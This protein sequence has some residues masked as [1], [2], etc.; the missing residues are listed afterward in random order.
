MPI[1]PTNTNRPGN[2][3][4]AIAKT[5]LIIA[6]IGAL[7]WGLVGLFQFNL[8][9][10]IFGG[11][12]PEQPSAAS[13]VVYVIVGLAGVVAAFLLPKL[14]FDARQTTGYADRPL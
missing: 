4:G 3:G 1:M 12:A 11:A 6:I 10:A 8:V 13:R 5:F 2:S 7:N 9:H 14:H